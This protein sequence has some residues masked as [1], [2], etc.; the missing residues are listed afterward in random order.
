[1]HFP[2]DARVG[3]QG[4]D[5]QTMLIYNDSPGFGDILQATQLIPKYVREYPRIIAHVP[6]PLHT[7]LQYSLPTVK[8]NENIEVP[9]M[10]RI[11][12]FTMLNERGD[13]APEGRAVLCPPP[14]PTYDL[15]PHKFHIG[16]SWCTHE[17]FLGNCRR[18]VPA[19][20]VIELLKLFIPNVEIHALH[21]D[22]TDELG[23]CDVKAYQFADFSDTAR[24]LKLV[25]CV[26]TVDG[27]I[28]HLGGGLG[29]PTYVMLNSN[30]IRTDWQQ[31]RV[32]PG[33]DGWWT[34]P[35]AHQLETPWYQ[36]ARLIWSSGTDKSTTDP[37]GLLDAAFTAIQAIRLR[38][39]L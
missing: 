30:L 34:N 39:E 6:Q 23:G 14:G 13:Y 16:L 9:G 10:K 3:Y 37:N 33:T 27:V 31:S 18:T 1:M 20:D 4:G 22:R 11:G 12:W 24:L 35:Q 5:Q 36:S 8:V 21:P 29:V 26:L 28:A 19:R 25:D 38:F 2:I 15:D 7:L 17:R 32:G